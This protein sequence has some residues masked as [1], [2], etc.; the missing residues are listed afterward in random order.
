[1]A[2]VTKTASFNQSATQQQVQ[3]PLKQVRAIIRRYVILEGLALVLLAA[4]SVFWVGLAIDFGLYKLQADAIGVYGVDWIQELNDVDASGLS[5]LGVRLIFMTVIVVG[6]AALG[7]TKVVTRWMSEFNDQAVA[8]VLERK[9]RKQLGDRLITAI[10]LADPQLSKKYGFSRPM[11][12]KTIMDC[13]KLLDQLPVSGVFNWSRLYKMWGLVALSSVGMLLLTMGATSAGTYAFASQGVSPITF[14]W[15]FFDVGM[16]WTERNVMMR[17]TYWPRSAYVEVEHWQ[18][19]KNNPDEMRVAK[20]DAR[21]ELQIRAFEWVIADRSSPSGWRALTWKDLGEKRLIKAE[22]LSAVT[23]PENHGGWKLDPA[24]LLEPN[25]ATAIFGGDMQ[26]RTSAEI[27]KHIAAPEIQAKV[28]TL[29]LGS[30]LASNLDWHTW[31]VDK[32]ATQLEETEVR[33]PLRGLNNGK[34]HEA[35]ESIFKE[36]AVLADSPSMSRTLRKLEAPG[37][38]AVNFRGEDSGYQAAYD[39]QTGNKYAVPLDP[40][41]DSNRFKFRARGADFF[42]R[43][44]TVELVASPTPASI[45]IDKEEPAY[46]YHRLHGVDQTPLTG[47]K[48]VTKNLDLPTGGDTNTIEVALGAKLVIHVRSDR[49]LR[50]EKAVFVKESPVIDPGFEHYRLQPVGFFS[51]G[52]APPAINKNGDG[53]S[54]TLSDLSRKYDF[55]MEFYDE[56]N[57]KGRRRFKVLSVLDTDPQVGN[58]NLYQVLLRKPKFKTE[59]PKEKEKDTRDLRELAE[60]SGAYL[61]TPDAVLPFEC[62]IKDDYGLVRAGYHYKIRTVDFEFTGGG[63]KKEGPKAEVDIG[64]RKTRAGIV[65]SN[66]QTWP[67]NPLTLWFGPANLAISTE[68]ALQNLRESQGYREEYVPAAG[69]NELLRARSHKMANLEA[70]KKTI[71]DIVNPPPEKDKEKKK[72][73]PTFAAQPW[74]WNFKDDEGFDVHKHLPSLKADDVAKSGQLH[75]YIQIAVQATDN[76]VETGPEYPI[77]VRKDNPTI[78]TGPVYLDAKG[79][80]AKADVLTSRGTSRK[81]KNG[82]MGFIIISENELLSQI[83]LEEEMLFEKLEVAKERVDAALTSL[84]AQQDL[85]RD[86]KANMD[87]VLNRMNEI[88]TVLA[89]S[90]QKIRECESAYKNIVAEMKVNRV[91]SERLAKI[92]ERIHWPLKDILVPAEN[93]RNT[94]GSFPDS[95]EAFHRAIQLVEDDVNAKRGPDADQHR[96]TMSA[97]SRQMGRLSYDLKRVLDA[98]NEG[99]VESKLIA[100]LATIERA[101]NEQ[102]RSLEKWKRKLEEELVERLLHPERFDKDGNRLPEKKKESSRLERQDERNY[103]PQAALIAQVADRIARLEPARR[104]EIRKALEK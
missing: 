70:V 93:A 82:Y 50:K 47:M 72:K 10:E 29:Q 79:Q 42:T 2:T 95:E 80:L 71:N 74:D 48:H 26:T 64:S 45:S 100:L 21:P 101:Q 67:G 14:S 65:L 44:K 83:A 90:G 16:I 6:L 58:L 77:Y 91:R 76:N 7:F 11:V 96:A 15:K 30:T 32:V 33:T 27:W 92:E 103:R 102:H 4:S 31:T 3:H 39:R 37:T 23:I 61:I 46:I 49:L 43:P 9:F 38:V 1:M 5:S 18:P 56:D 97:A 34:D 19:A 12:E 8:L 84:A 68:Y 78:E 35:L 87:I 25:Y 17:D 98:M 60:L 57:I 52:S 86:P 104:E 51:R 81:N 89:D 94:T 41:K 53:F 40:L 73:M 55:T 36:L 13:V 54:I 66:M 24:D 69:F 75:Y 59:A 22:L 85:T 28:R 63:T 99:I 20:D 62:D 88:R